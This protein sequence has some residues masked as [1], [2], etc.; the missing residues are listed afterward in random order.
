MRLVVV[1]VL[2]SAIVACSA[3]PETTEEEAAYFSDCRDIDPDATPASLR[4]AG[5]DYELM[6]QRRCADGGTRVFRAPGGDAGKARLVTLT[7]YPPEAEPRRSLNAYL[8]RSASERVGEPQM[9]E[10]EAPSRAQYL[11]ELMLRDDDAAELEYVLHGVSRTDGGRVV[12]V[13][14]T[15]RF[16]M[17]N[18]A[19]LARIRA[20]QADWLGAVSRQLSRFPDP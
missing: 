7:L 12:S 8:A 15:H 2:A 16:A 10:P 14:Y 11:A 4:F 9:F 6:W 18:A 17:A 5:E 3:T 19:G 1:A 20:E 13:T